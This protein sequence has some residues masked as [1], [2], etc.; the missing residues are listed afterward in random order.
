VETAVT[1]PHKIAADDPVVEALGHMT[2]DAL[3]DAGHGVLLVARTL[4][5]GQLARE[6]HIPRRE[7]RRLVSHTKDHQIRAAMAEENV[8]FDAGEVERKGVREWIR[9]NW[10]LIEKIAKIILSIVVML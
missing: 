8:A 7:A 1:D 2:E 4:A 10:D 9:E 5:V 6:R 3:D